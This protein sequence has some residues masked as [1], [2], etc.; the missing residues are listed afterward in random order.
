M[1]RLTQGL[2]VVVFTAAIFSVIMVGLNDY[3]NDQRLGDIG[4]FVRITAIDAANIALSRCLAAMEQ[5]QLERLIMRICAL[6]T[7]HMDKV[8]LKA[9]LCLEKNWQAFIQGRHSAS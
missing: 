4:S 9:A 3:T 2:H 8:R 1:S 6:A 5:F 7:E